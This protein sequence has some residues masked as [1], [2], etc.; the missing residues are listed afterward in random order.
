MKLN[1]L[2]QAINNNPCDTSVLKEFAKHL[3]N[4]KEWESL[5][6]VNSSL[7]K[8]EP[9][10]TNIVDYA[11][12]LI[13]TGDRTKIIKAA[14]LLEEILNNMLSLEPDLSF[15]VR[16]LAGN[17][18]LQLSNFR[19]AL[20]YYQNCLK[21]REDS[22]VLLTNIGVAF[23]LLNDYAG[24][25]EAYLNALSINPK[26]TQALAGLAMIY[27]QTGDLN[28]TYEYSLKALD[29]DPV[30]LTAL[31]CL[32]KSASMLG[33]LDELSLRLEKYLERDALN[34]S[35]IYTHAGNLF[36]LGK[37]QEALLEIYKLLTIEPDHQF[38]LELLRIIESMSIKREAV[39]E[40]TRV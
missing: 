8:L 5:C 29:V 21:L 33:E 19:L 16:R 31:N 4:K 34:S 1:E 3:K 35:I 26:Y 18:H 17:A 22:E 30:E 11:E 37:I 12:T 7:C 36:Q 24:A 28:K 6:T 14:A 20:T 23:F 2:A 32:V 13:N 39:I 9:S 27:S 15:K 38:G 40:N 25:E 10:I